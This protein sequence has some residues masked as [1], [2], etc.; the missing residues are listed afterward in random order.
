M[1]L[2][3]FVKVNE[4]SGSLA[5]RDAVCRDPRDDFAFTRV[6]VRDWIGSL[7][8]EPP[9]PHRGGDSPFVLRFILGANPP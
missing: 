6:S 1:A 4:A 8:S 3:E 5:A 2:P 7:D 9:K